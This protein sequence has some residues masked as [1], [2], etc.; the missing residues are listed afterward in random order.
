MCV[1]IKIC[2]SNFR[3]AA[4]SLGCHDGAMINC[5]LYRTFQSL[6]VD[7]TETLDVNSLI[8]RIA[9]VSTVEDL[10]PVYTIQP[11]VKPV[12]QPAA[13]CKQT[14]NRLLSRSDNG[15]N[16]CLHDT[17]GCSTA[18]V[19]PLPV[20]QLVVQP[21]EQPAA[22]CKQKFNRLY[23]VNGVLRAFNTRCEEEPCGHARSSRSVNSPL[24]TRV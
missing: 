14:F 21:V 13:S 7:R 10:Y 20:E 4:Y 19:K 18:V 24:C 15:W 16:V 1:C 23:R 2:V 22:S 6:T 3:A 11:I 9:S 5:R 8:L 17:A 12:E